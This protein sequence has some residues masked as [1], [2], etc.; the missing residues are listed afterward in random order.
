MTSAN[1]YATS[2]E[3]FWSAT[4]GAPGEIFWDA[5]PTHA[6]QQDL[7]LF[8]AYANSQLPLIDLGC[9]NGTQTRYLANHFAKVIGAEIAHAAVQ[10]AERTNGAANVTYR[11]LDVLR[12]DDA[13]H[14]YDEIG[15]ANVYMRAVLHQ[16]S[17]TDHATA[18]QSIERLLG[19]KGILYL[20]EL[21]SAAEPFFAKLIA[22]YGPPPGLARVFQHQI[23]P[24]ML[25]DNNLDS[26]FPSDRF[27]LLGQ[28]PSHIRTVH[29][30]PTGEV[31]KVPAFY[32]IFRRR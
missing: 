27:R 21:S 13:Q 15:D 30:L 8:K 7:A 4:T 2:W 26:L 5:D 31:V 29:S 12:P 11:V 28:G 22:E 23:T 25:H 18:V 1:R 14:L 6:A 32:A 20:V 16:L 10:L 9:G 24:G 3:N 17:P 19:K